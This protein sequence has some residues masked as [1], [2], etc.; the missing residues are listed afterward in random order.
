MWHTG[1][2]DGGFASVAVTEDG[3]T[4]THR[5]GN[6][7]IL[8]TAPT[9]KPRSKAPPGPPPP[10]PPAPT[11]PPAPPGMKWDCHAEQEADS[12]KLKLKDKDIKCCLT[13][14]KDCTNR[15]MKTSGCIA[16]N[17]HTNDDHCHVLTGSTTHDQFVSALHQKSASTACMMVKG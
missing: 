14:V 3:L 1:A 8:Y 2:G 6:G 16:V 5:D 15:C 4:V 12:G 13:D 10:P 9:A 11:P 7:K 17:W